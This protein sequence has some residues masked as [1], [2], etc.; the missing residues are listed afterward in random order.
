MRMFVTT[1]AI[2][3]ALTVSAFAQGGLAATETQGQANG[4][5]T[6]STQQPTEPALQSSLPRRTMA[7][8]NLPSEKIKTSKSSK[9]KNLKPASLKSGASSH[10]SAIK[11]GGKPD[12]PYNDTRYS[13]E[14]L[15]SP[16][17]M[18]GGN[19]K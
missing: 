14:S 17:G 6:T 2:M 18:D 1:A 4:S 12:E 11:A 3:A 8:G 13:P 5:F 7:Q 19:R 9:G 15:R 16:T 10:A